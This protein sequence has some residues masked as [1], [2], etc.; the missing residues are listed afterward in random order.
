VPV[1]FFGGLKENK[2][3]LDKAWWT[4]AEIDLALRCA[5]EVDQDLQ[6]G[7][8]SRHEP[9]ATLLV[10]AGCFL[11]LRYEEIVM[12]RWQD[13]ELDAVDQNRRP[14]PVAKVVPHAGWRPKDGDARVVPIHQRLHGVLVA[15]CKKDGYVLEP[16]KAMP[17][18]G[19]T[20]RVYRYD[21]K[22][23]WNRVI[24]KVVAAGGKTITPNGMR[25]SFASNLL[26][27]GVSDVLVARW[28]GHADT[29]M[30]H[31]HYGHLLA[32]HG[33]INLV[34]VPE[35]AKSPQLGPELGPQLLA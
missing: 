33:A 31:E 34:Q 10:A 11:G 9:T 27:A 6:Y 25:H 3:H 28:L 4:P 2:N 30:V 12:L 17:K 32:Y 5:A 14:A 23:V 24:R 18:R 21:P 7:D 35:T 15:H 16:K 26:M 20:K 1:L 29:S 8:E 19:G 22:C 13:L